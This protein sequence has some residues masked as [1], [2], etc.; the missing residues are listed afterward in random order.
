MTRLAAS[1]A[2]LWRDIL[3]ANRENT[4]TALSAFADELARAVAAM[5]ED[6]EIENLFDRAAEA[7]T[8]LVRE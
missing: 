4:I 3:S 5:R 2:V 1:P 6:D 7:R 8:H